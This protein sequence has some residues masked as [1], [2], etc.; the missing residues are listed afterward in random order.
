MVSENHI[1]LS[2][3]VTKVIDIL[4]GII[5]EASGLTMRVK[6]RE[7]AWTLFHQARCTIVSDLWLDLIQKMNV[8]GT[9]S[10]LFQTVTK[11]V[12]EVR[13]MVFFSSHGSTSNMLNLDEEISED[14]KNVIMYACSYVPVALI[15]RYEKRKA[16]KYAVFVQCL[17]QMAIGS[18]E[19]SFYDYA[20]KW[21]DCVNRGVHLKSVTLHSTF[22]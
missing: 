8:F 17:L 19:E 20:R 18:F 6:Q 3:F 1:T 5:H 2:I 7:K 12:F 13:L 22:S 9:N 11:K 4:D 21:Y 10:L 15:H 14:E 16:A